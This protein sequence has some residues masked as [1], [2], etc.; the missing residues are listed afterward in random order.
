MYLSSCVL[1]IYIYFAI[2]KKKKDYMTEICTRMAQR[3][4]IKPLKISFGS[5]KELLKL[6]TCCLHCCSFDQPLFSLYLEKQELSNE[7][8]KNT[9]SVI[10]NL[11]G[12]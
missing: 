9:K 5:D 7:A 1:F 10:S 12:N 4:R 2:Q 11:R 3:E 8:F 6:V